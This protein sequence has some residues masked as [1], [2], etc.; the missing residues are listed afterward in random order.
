MV[1]PLDLANQN[2]FNHIPPIIFQDEHV[3]DVKS[4]KYTIFVS[5]QHWMQLFVGFMG[6]AM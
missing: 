4:V 6:R 3:I 2:S 5:C 1:R